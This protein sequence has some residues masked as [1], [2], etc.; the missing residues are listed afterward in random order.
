MRVPD[1]RD[2]G[3]DTGTGRTSIDPMAR[4]L[5]KVEKQLAV[6]QSR[7]PYNPNRRGM[8]G[9]G[10]SDLIS[11]LTAVDYTATTTSSSPTWDTLDIPSR[12][13]NL[14]WDGATKVIVSRPCEVQIHVGVQFLPGASTTYVQ[15]GCDIQGHQLISVKMPVY[16]TQTILLEGSTF[17]RVD[18][19]D[20]LRARTF[21]FGADSTVDAIYMDVQA[22]FF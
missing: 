5:A 17:Y 22:F 20:Y 1:L 15:I 8:T 18:A 14:T 16:S 9:S 13:G 6:L 19:G 7:Q 11:V 2:H 12:T 10:S 4:R 3:N 21:S